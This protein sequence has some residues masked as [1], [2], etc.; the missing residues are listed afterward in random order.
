MNKS[1]SR[2][3]NTAI[4]MDEALL[5]IL[6][7]KDYEYITVKEICEKAGVNRSTFYLHYESINDLLAESIDYVNSQFLDYVKID[8]VG[9]V[10]RI[11]SCPKEELYLLTP[12]YLTPY[13]NYIKEHKRLF[14]TMVD[15][16]V[17]LRL[18]KT[19]N[20]MFQHVF[21]PILERFQVQKKDREYMMVFYMNGLMAIIK[22]WL[23]NDCQDSIEHIISVMERCV[24]HK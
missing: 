18:D 1:E 23:K 21:E 14:R 6:E 17:S 24:M 2:Y 20:R 7:K 12:E 15:N 13:L 8:A 19:Y 3:F 9:V 22:C 10:S 4:R 16:P 11:R 5:E